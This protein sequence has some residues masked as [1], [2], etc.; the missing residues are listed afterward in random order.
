MSLEE[1][2]RIDKTKVR[3]NHMFKFEHQ[4][5]YKFLNLPYLKQ[6]LSQRIKIRLRDLESTLSFPHGLYHLAP[7]C[8]A[9]SL[10]RMKPPLRT[11]RKPDLTVLSFLCCALYSLELQSILKKHTYKL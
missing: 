6:N 11:K 1:N 10:K 3:I 9:P 4:N 2:R 8:L 7:L 5:T